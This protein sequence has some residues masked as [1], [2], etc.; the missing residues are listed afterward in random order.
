MKINNNIS[1]VITNKHLLR[2]ENALSESM[3]R[4]SSGLKINHSS[5]APAGLAISSRMQAQIDALDR[6]SQNASDVQSV[7]E[8]ADAGLEA[9]TNM[10][11]RIRELAVQAAN[12]TN[13][14]QE[15]DAIQL[16]VENLKE[17]V[18]RI[19]TTTEFNTK[20]LLDGAIDKRVYAEDVTRVSVSDAV[21]E[22][23]YQIEVED[24]AKAGNISMSV[25]PSSWGAVDP[26]KG[27]WLTNVEGN[28]S[29]NGGTASITSG[30]TLDEVYA[31]VEKAATLGNAEATFDKTNNSWKFESVALGRNS[32]VNV[33]FSPSLATAVSNVEHTVRDETTG[34][35]SST[36]LTWAPDPT[37]GNYEVKDFGEDPR[38]TIYQST[39]TGKSNYSKDSA[40][41]D[42][43]NVS[44]NG[45][46]VTITDDEG[47]K[48]DFLLNSDIDV[49]PAANPKKTKKIDFDVADIGPENMQVGAN[50]GQQIQIRIPGVTSKHLYLD[51]VN[52]A[53]EGGAARAI[54]HMDVSIA[55][56]NAARSKVGAYMNRLEHTIKSLDQTEEN[57]TASISRITDTNMA[58]EMSEF[59]KYNVLVQ[60]AT[61]ALSQANELPQQA[62]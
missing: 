48:L 59:T 54:E 8:T 30:M 58:K 1:A 36:G 49:D 43:A 18:D 28:I 46:R 15:K 11:Q 7:L 35:S 2:Q 60:A 47:F 22:G 31:A 42:T 56:V 40:F 20:H 45:N 50:E 41:A 37:T 12:D 13:S 23:T 34:I 24:T 9:I 4:L 55:Y 14:Q 26:N 61:S 16:E 5:D 53:V 29:I 10:L 3:E 6:A 21:T 27:V 51:E 25:T 62:L 33:S 44:Y 17:E 52:V 32:I 19:A 38:I 57:M 39:D